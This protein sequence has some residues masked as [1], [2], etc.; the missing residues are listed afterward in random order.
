[1]RL[2]DGTDYEVPAELRAELSKTYRNLNLDKELAKMALWLQ[3][4][5]RKRK[6]ARGILRFLVNWLNKAQPEIA[7]MLTK[8][9][10]CA[11]RPALHTHNGNGYCTLCLAAL[12]APAPTEPRRIGSL[13]DKIVRAA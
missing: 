9:V 6:S 8:C 12:V 4:N 13:F 1:M 3:A 10:R 5:P 11:M 7:P 2:K